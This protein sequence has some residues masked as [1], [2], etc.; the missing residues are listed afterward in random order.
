[1]QPI[2][3]R[4]HWTVEDLITGRKY[5]LKPKRKWLVFIISAAVAVF[6]IGLQSGHHPSHTS[7]ENHLPEK[8]VALGVVVGAI[9]IAVPVGKFIGATIIRRQ[10]AK[11]PDANEEIAWEFSEA[12]IATSSSN[13]KSEIKWPAFYR[14]LATPAGFLFMPNHQIFHFIPNRAFASSA[15]IETVKSLARQHATVFKEMK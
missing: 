2:P 7:H 9:L 12:G 14:V 15:D 1:M 10:F 6:T 13:A 3:A 8:L 11:R 4:F 5:A